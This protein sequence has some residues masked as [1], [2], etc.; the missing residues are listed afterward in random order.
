VCALRTWREAKVI[1]LPKN[2]KAPFT[3]S[4]SWPISCYQPLVNF[5]NNRLFCCYIFTPFF[6]PISWYPIGSSYSLVSSLELLYGLRRGDCWEPCVLR[7][8]TQTSRTMTQC[9]S[10][11]KP[12]APMYRRKDRTPGDRVS[13]H[14]PGP[15]QESLVHDETRISLLAKPSPNP[16]DAGP[17]VRLPMGLLV[18]A[19]CG[20]AWTQTQNL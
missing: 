19:G 4:N 3:G 9:P 18:T 12:A 11:P 16:D 8:T 20:R 14:C 5:W 10:N 2:S 13:V 17:I 7:N 15:P 6:S 1:P